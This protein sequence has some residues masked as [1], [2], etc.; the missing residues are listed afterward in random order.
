M[1]LVIESVEVLCLAGTSTP[2]FSSQRIYLVLVQQSRTVA[3]SSIPLNGLSRHEGHSA[4]QRWPL[5][6]ELDCMELGLLAAGSICVF[7]HRLLCVFY[8]PFLSLSL[9]F[10][11]MSGAVGREDL[12]LPVSTKETKI[13]C[14]KICNLNVVNLKLWSGDRFASPHYVCLPSEKF[15]LIYFR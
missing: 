4:P 11:Q 1:H 2:C 7:L 6:V 14:F 15:S 3:L 8:T 9:Y 10:W 12:P 13:W 5:N